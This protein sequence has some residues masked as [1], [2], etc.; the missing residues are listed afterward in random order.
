MAV[1]KS[2]L[3]S[4][5]TEA[6]DKLRG[7][8]DASQYK[9]YVLVLLFLKYL[10]D[11]IKVDKDLRESV[12]LPVDCTYEAIGK[13]KNKKSIGGDLNV[14]LGK[15]AK[16]NPALLDGV[17]NNPDADFADENKL[18]K[19]VDLVKCVSGLIKIFENPDLDF[20]HNRAADDDLIGDAYEYLLKHFAKQS[21]GSKGQFMT[22]TEASILLAR[23]VGIDLD[24]RKLISLFD[25]TC[26]SASLLLRAKSEAHVNVSLDG[27]EKDNATIGMAKMNMVIHGVP[28]ADLQH[29]DTIA[30]PF[31]TE[32]DHIKQYDY[33]LANFPFSQ[34]LELPTDDKFNRWGSTDDKPPRPPANYEDYAFILHIVAAI[35]ERTGKGATVAPHGVLFRGND[36]G[37]IRKWLCRH[38]L[39]SGVIGLPN[40]L[41]YGTP[42]QACMIVFDKT[43]VVN[44]KGVFFVNAKD[45]FRKDG[46]KNRLREED[47]RK[48]IDAWRAKKDI[49]HFSRFVE[50]SEIEK[51]DCNLSIQRYV[52]PLDTEIQQD[53]TAHLHGGLPANDVDEVFAPYWESCGTLKNSLFKK[54][55]GGYYALKPSV[56][57]IGETIRTD[58]SFAAQC[59]K[60]VRAIVR[61]CDMTRDDFAAQMIGS[62]PKVCIERWGTSLL[63]AM[64]KNGS[65]V[66]PYD[67]YQILADYWAE[68][69]QDDCYLV[70]RDGW[71]APIAPIKAK[72][73]YVYTDYA[74]DLVPVD[75]VVREFFKDESDRIAVLESEIAANEGELETL[76]EEADDAFRDLWNEKKSKA[77]TAALEASEEGERALAIVEKRDEAKV[78]KNAC[79]KDLTEKVLAKYAAFTEDE[80]RDLVVDRKWILAITMR[81]GE[82]MTRL[83]QQIETDV[84]AL[85]KR[86]R[87]TVG[88][89]ESKVAALKAKVNKHLLAM[90]ERL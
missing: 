23:L 26:G 90:G 8:M 85:E 2:E 12:N 27:Q 36:E 55:K 25:P 43:N 88:E 70:S 73:K 58:T 3:Y 5:L 13:L 14:I 54:G 56:E 65:L 59:D 47:I 19:G 34:K 50:W 48:I 74:C 49:P 76:L 15:I 33:V 4:S 42:I 31:H 81:T 72:K 75:L 80:I 84:K 60:F 32:G 77:R 39:I 86:Y 61:W 67:V 20:S 82:A 52:V 22:P 69:M 53:I 79:V 64:K 37:E 66:D 10:S 1:K 21:G 46:P 51:N 71:T 29:D 16:A 17:V 87:T 41:F 45:G 7:G 35:K 78:Q 57:K 62:N 18:G 40:N 9:N 63:E 44:S 6:C 38:R 28:D 30:K 83:A 11:R 24:T 89:A 68:T